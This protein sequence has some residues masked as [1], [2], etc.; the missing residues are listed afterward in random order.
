[1]VVRSA[2]RN[3]V[4]A[5]VT[6]R[7]GGVGGVPGLMVTMKLTLLLAARKS[8]SFIVNARWPRTVVY[9]GIVIAFASIAC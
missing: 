4:L 6:I 3:V 7:A 9:V 5:L 8:A 2:D 1:M